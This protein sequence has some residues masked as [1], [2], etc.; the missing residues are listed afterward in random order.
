MLR[1]RPR[2]IEVLVAGDFLEQPRSAN[3]QITCCSTAI[4]G[5]DDQF[6][7]GGICREQFKKQSAQAVGFDETHELIQCC[8]RI[9]CQSD[10][11]Q[12]VWPQFSEDLFCSRRN[13]GC[14]GWLQQIAKRSG[15]GLFVFEDG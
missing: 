3:E 13:M 2:L 6:Q 10:L 1:N 11:P 4:E 15:G 8:I 5:S 14:G 12:K 9:S 7:Q